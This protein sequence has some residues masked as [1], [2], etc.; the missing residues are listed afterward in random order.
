MRPNCCYRQLQCFDKFH[1]LVNTRRQTKGFLV[2]LSVLNLELGTLYFVRSP[3]IAFIRTLF[4]VSGVGRTE[5]QAQSTKLKG[6]G[7]FRFARAE[8]APRLNTPSDSVAVSGLNLV[9]NMLQGLRALRLP[10]L[11]SRHRFAVF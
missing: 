10:L 5:N 7:A 6:Q 3:N 4:F 2:Q 11:P 1:G 8:G 9:S